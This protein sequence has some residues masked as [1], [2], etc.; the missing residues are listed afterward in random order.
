MYDVEFVFKHMTKCHDLD[1]LLD[2]T[3]VNNE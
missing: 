3:S 2:Q 1:R